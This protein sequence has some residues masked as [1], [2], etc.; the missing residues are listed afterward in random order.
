MVGSK[1]FSKEFMIRHHIP[2]A[3]HRSF[4]NYELAREFL[5]NISHKVVL[6][7]S[8]LAAGKEVIIPSSKEEAQNALEDI[9]KEKEFGA[10]GDEVVIEEFLESDELSF[11]TF[12]DGYTIRS[13]PSAQDHKQ[14]YIG[15][16]GPNRQHGLLCTY[17]DCYTKIDKAGAS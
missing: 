1:A 4:T 5:D 17:E 6:K 7:T 16:Q 9:M 14:V 12:S 13:L 10:A 11:L 8:G 15:D 3:T 2:T